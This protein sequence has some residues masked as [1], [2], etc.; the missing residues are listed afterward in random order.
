MSSTWPTRGASVLRQNPLRGNTSYGS[1]PAIVAPFYCYSEYISGWNTHLLSLSQSF[2]PTLLLPLR[3]ILCVLVAKDFNEFKVCQIFTY[4][5]SFFFRDGRKD[6]GRKKW[7]TAK[8]LLIPGHIFTL[9]SLL[10]F[11]WCR[12]A[13]TVSSTVSTNSSN[14]SLIIR[15]FFCTTLLYSTSLAASSLFCSDFGTFIP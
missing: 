4:A 1:S 8:I 10:S 15:H 13:C 7:E 2:C 5:E 12:F 3:P 11:C 6:G 9:I 14:S